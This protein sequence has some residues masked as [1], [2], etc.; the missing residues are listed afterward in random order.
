MPLIYSPSKCPFFNLYLIK[1]MNII[2]IRMGHIEGQGTSGCSSSSNSSS[3]CSSCSG[4]NTGNTSRKWWQSAAIVAAAA[5]YQTAT[6]GA[7]NTEGINGDTARGSCN[8][9][10]TRGTTWGQQQQY[11]RKIM[12]Q[13]YYGQQEKTR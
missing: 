8:T 1:P 3:T 12:E 10:W 4:S 11:W 9:N 7:T 6:A 13:C 2:I 5:G